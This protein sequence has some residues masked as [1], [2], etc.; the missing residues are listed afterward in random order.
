MEDVARYSS[1]APAREE[2][3]AWPGLTLLQFGAT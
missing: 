1:Q 2:V 3:D